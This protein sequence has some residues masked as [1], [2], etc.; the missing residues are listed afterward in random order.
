MSFK[1]S[2]KENFRI[3]LS[4]WY[5]THGRTLP[6]RENHHAYLIWLS[7]II[8]QQTRVEQ[9]LPY[10]H[11]FKNRFPTVFDLAEAD[12][13][14]ILKL[15]QGLGYYSRARNLHKAAKQVVEHH[16]G[17]FPANYKELLLLQ[18]IG[19]YTAAAIASIAFNLPEAVVDGNVVR[20]IS[21]L[22]AITD[23]VDESTTKKEIAAKA[24]E[25]L[26]KL[27]PGNHNQAMMDFGAMI[28]TPKQPKCNAC[29]VSQHCVALA[30]NKVHVVPFKTQKTKKRD[31]FFHF[32]VAQDSSLLLIEKRDEAD[33]WAGLYQF[34]LVETTQNL[35]LD[36]S[37]IEARLQVSN[38]KLNAVRSMPKHILSHQTIY[39][40]FYAVEANLANVSEFLKIKPSELHTF[41]VPRLIDRY[42]EKHSI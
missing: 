9:G 27:N 7:E 21:R 39:A 42:L 29:P 31:R 17:Q 30:V 4:A 12:E 19:P 23:S 18:G 5:N 35:E 41:A 20:V 2:M 34:P 25:L 8:L 28:C 36:L 24:Y 15:W 16:G 3:Q 32:L 37:S 1:G 22:F 26:D 11:S 6:W 40:R 13:D 14:E 38:I 33:I 10:F